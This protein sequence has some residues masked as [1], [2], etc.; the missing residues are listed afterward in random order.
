MPNGR[1]NRRHAAMRS[2]FGPA[3]PPQRKATRTV[4]TSRDDEMTREPII[5]E[6]SDPTSEAVFDYMKTLGD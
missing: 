4:T 2:L 5:G 1:Y 3:H 6:M